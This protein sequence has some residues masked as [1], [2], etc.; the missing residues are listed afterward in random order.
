M[1]LLLAGCATTQTEP[2]SV[3]PAS[4]ESID[5]LMIV[6]DAEVSDS[7]AMLTAIRPAISGPAGSL[8]LYD[9]ATQGLASLAGQPTVAAVKKY[10]QAAAKN[11]PKQLDKIRA[12]KV[13]LDKKTDE[14]EAKVEAEKVAR[15]KAE[16]RAEAA[17]LDKLAAEEAKDAE[18]RRANKTNTIATMVQVGAAAMAA[19]LA[20]FF[21]GH[22]VGI[23]KL[24]AGLVV[25]GGMVIAAGAPI[26]VDMVELKWVVLGLSVF[27]VLDVLVIVALKTWRYIKPPTNA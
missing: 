8:S 3:K 7:L 20:A 17:E 25:A 26:I 19:G 12:E 27:L 16:A 2:P 9:S 1:A 11:D 22:F 24:T 15:I 4:L 10:E 21:F 13:A 6:W 18:A 5:G 23:S 14:L